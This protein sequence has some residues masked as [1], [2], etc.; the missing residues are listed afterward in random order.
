MSFK[1]GWLSCIEKKLDN[2]GGHHIARQGYKALF[3]I[4]DTPY[5]NIFGTAFGTTTLQL[6]TSSTLEQFKDHY[7]Q[8]L[9]IP[10]CAA[11]HAATNVYGM[12]DD[13]EWVGDNWDH[14]LIQANS[15]A[16]GSPLGAS[17]QAEVDAHFWLGV[18][19]HQWYTENYCINPANTDVGENTD[20]PSE[21]DAGT[22]ASQYPVRYFRVGYDIDGNI[23]NDSPHVEFFVI[24]CISYRSPLAATDDAG[25]TMLGATQKQWLMDRLA[26]STAIFK[27]VVTPK[28]L[29]RNL[30][31][32]NG[33]VWGYYTTEREEI[34]DH[35]DTESITGIAWLAGDRHTPQVSQLTV[36]GGGAHDTL[37]ITA[38]PMGVTINLGAADSTYTEGHVWI[39]TT[40]RVW[41]EAEIGVDR[42]T[43]RIRK[44]IDGGTLWSGYI[45][46]GSNQVMYPQ[47]RF[48]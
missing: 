29:Q 20:K 6:T 11:Y 24:D 40:E 36:A 18:Q 25:K 39:N 26:A 10:G 33:D 32:D 34:L 1:I 12:A 3:E 4:G 13:H 35:I 31:S 30:G 44:S 8:H 19:A 23:D 17:T 21:A 38:C 27:L 22:P 2:Y 45:E 15:G 42:V 7:R 47:Q 28:K 5:C 14:T 43:F 48:G 37:C 16:S 41:G 46:A 9:S